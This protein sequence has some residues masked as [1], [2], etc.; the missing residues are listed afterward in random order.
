MLAPF[1]ANVDAIFDKET[2][3]RLQEQFG[4]EYRSALE[5]MLKRMTS[6]KNR[7]STDPISPFQKWLQRAVS[8][9]MFWNTRSAVLQSLSSFNFVGLPNNNL[10][11]AATGFSWKTFSKLYNSPYLQERRSDSRFD[12]LAEDV[13]S[14]NDTKTDRFFNKLFGGKYGGF[15]PTK[16]IDSF[17]IAFGGASFFNNRSKAL[18]KEGLS[19][20]EA[21]KQAYNEWIAAA[22][23]SQQSSDPSKISQIQATDSGK[24]FFAF[25]NTPF[26]YARIAKRKMQDIANGRSKNIGKDAATAF[27]YTVG[28]TALFTTLQTGLIAAA[29]GQFGDDENDELFFD[30]MELAFDRGFGSLMKSMGWGGAGLATA[31]A[32]GKEMEAQINGKKRKDPS[33]VA[34]AFLSTSPQVSIKVNQLES[35]IR[36]LNKKKPDYI[37]TATRATEFGLALPADRL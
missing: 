23:T 5:N 1:K 28:Q 26:Q 33:A 30:K 15:A 17:A 32:V 21:E 20:T 25:A 8:T 6:G 2:L 37:K 35:I 3:D 14:G 22:E 10:A 16:A 4:F 24:L 12:V 36:E 7:L 34:K 19:K 13:A 31:Y 29:M 11:Q 9:T 18:I 27:Y